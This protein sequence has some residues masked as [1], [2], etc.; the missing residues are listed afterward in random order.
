MPG[1]GPCGR[2][3]DPHACEINVMNL[4]LLKERVSSIGSSFPEH[5]TV[6]C[7]VQINA[8]R[9]PHLIIDNFFGAEELKEIQHHEPRVAGKEIKILRSTIRK[10]G[11]VESEIFDSSFL[12][13]INHKYLPPLQD[14]LGIFSER[15][16]EIYDY[17]DFHLI[18]TGPDYEHKIHDDVPRKLLSVVVYI[19]PENNN[20]TFIHRG[21]YAKSPA[22]EV[23]WR[24]NRAFIFSRLERKTWHSYAA[25]KIN[26]RYCVI[27]N[28]GTYKTYKAHLAERN[29][30]KYLKKRIKNE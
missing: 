16:K 14:I 30:F 13:E 29:Y 19:N 12:N 10:T 20:G 8:C 15:K 21:K 24:Q 7:D 5:W 6:A 18:S 3:P 11:E 28:L 1:T 26:K 27:Y 23:E 4:Q 22:G 2:N 9:F 17:T 25:D